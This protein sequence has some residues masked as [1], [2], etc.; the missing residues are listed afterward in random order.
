MNKLFD[1][2]SDKISTE[3]LKNVVNHKAQNL[4]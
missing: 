1:T 3:N 2:N 4:K